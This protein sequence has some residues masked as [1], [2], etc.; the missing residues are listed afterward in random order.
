MKDTMSRRKAFTM[1][2]LMIALG[3]ITLLASLL[4]PIVAATRRVA[5]R[6]RM[7][8][9]VMAIGQGLEAYRLDHRDYPRLP[10][11]QVWTDSADIDGSALLCRALL[12]PGP[13]AQDG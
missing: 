1:V 12:S 6:S 2:E 5:V 7:K 8:A 11:T 10:D 4:I 13:A 9:D 3:I